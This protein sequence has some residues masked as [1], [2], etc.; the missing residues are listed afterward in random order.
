MHFSQVTIAGQYFF[1]ETQPIQMSGFLS[2][3]ATSSSWFFFQFVKGA[4]DICGALHE[5]GYWADFIDPS[6]GRPVSS[7]T[8]F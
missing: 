6:S 8:I 2:G 1:L 4:S 5:A 7:V 3:H